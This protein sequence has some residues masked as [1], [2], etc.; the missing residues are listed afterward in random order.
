MDQ[1]TGLCRGWNFQEEE[2]QKIAGLGQI[3][4]QSADD[5]ILV[6]NIS[7]YSI[8]HSVRME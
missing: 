6:F 3:T 4:L 8:I 7:V 5:V 2:M 1:S